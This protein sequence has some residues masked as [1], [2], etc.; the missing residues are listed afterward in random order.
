MRFTDLM[1]RLVGAARTETVAN[2]RQQA[3]AEVQRAGGDSPEVIEGFIF[4]MVEAGKGVEWVVLDKRFLDPDPVLEW[5]LRSYD[6]MHAL[7]NGDE[8]TIY[9][10]SDARAVIWSGHIELDWNFE[11]FWT[12]AV[13]KGVNREVWRR[14]F[15]NT[16][17]ATLRPDPSRKKR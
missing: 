3:R 4:A 15:T 1:K 9:D 13:Q 5:R 17:P 10:K 14:W 12:E 11:G 8:L 6:G 16:H 7:E 2:E